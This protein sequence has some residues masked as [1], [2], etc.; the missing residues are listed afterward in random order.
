MDDAELHTLTGAYAVN[1]VPEDER[2][3]FER[4]LERCASCAREVSELSATAARLGGAMSRPAAPAMRRAVLERITRVRQESPRG[5]VRR[6]V[7]RLPP[8]TLAACLAAA[9]LGGT[10]A[11]QWYSAEQAR[12][13]VERAERRADELAAVLSSPDVRVTTGEVPGGGRA[14]VILSPGHDRAAFLASGLPTP[15]DGLVY[16]L[17]FD[18]GGAMR[19][20]G[21]LESGGEEAM[22]MDGRVGQATGMGITVE[23]A[24]GSARPTSEPLAA[25]DFAG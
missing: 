7:R 1:A 8:L 5:A 19:P 15:P 2:A 25:M 14:T 6:A 12:E 11:W 4:H 10:T 9:L 21:L 3:R 18:E 22:L 20:A 23:P 16:Q 17:W 13:R 24:G